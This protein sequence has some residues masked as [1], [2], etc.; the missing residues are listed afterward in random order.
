MPKVIKH[1]Q[2]PVTP[3]TFDVLGLSESEFYVLRSLIGAVK[4]AAM[5]PIIASSASS[6][7]SLPYYD[8]GERLVKLFEALDVAVR[9]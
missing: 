9:G 1:T 4:H 7:Y 3:A 2:V 8:D 5:R 6:W